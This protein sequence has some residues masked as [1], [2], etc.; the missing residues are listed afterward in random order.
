MEGFFENIIIYK[1]R[2]ESNQIV[3]VIQ[4]Q[5][6]IL[7]TCYKTWWRFM[8]FKFQFCGVPFLFCQQFC[9]VA[10]YKFCD[11]NWYTYQGRSR[12]GLVEKLRPWFESFIRIEHRYLRS[13]QFIMTWKSTSQFSPL[14]IFHLFSQIF[15]SI[16]I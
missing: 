13:I 16:Y 5:L 14:D 4:S 8:R 7:E 10:F 3:G 9:G 1:N 12:I 11:I 15:I 2:Y 6:N